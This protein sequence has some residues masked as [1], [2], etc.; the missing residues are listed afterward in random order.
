MEN[1]KNEIKELAAKM[2]LSN[3]ATKEYNLNKGTIPSGNSKGSPFGI[4][5]LVI[6]KAIESLIEEGYSKAT[7]DIIMD[8]AEFLGLYEIKPSKSNKSYIF[9]WWLSPLKANGFIA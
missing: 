9:S 5:A 3:K 2:N 4:H 8:R 6:A 1:L 7:K